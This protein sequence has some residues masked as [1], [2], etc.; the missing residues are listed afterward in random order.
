VLPT[1]ATTGK[2]VSELLA[3]VMQHQEFRQQSGMG[4]VRT[5]A[6]RHEEFVAVLRDEIAR[7]LEVGLDSG[8]LGGV[9]QQVRRG[10]IDP[11]RAALQVMN[12]EQAVQVL[13][14]TRR[15]AEAKQE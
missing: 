6:A 7:R 15:G 4:A 13:I 2:G 8:C 11:Y 9:L 12:D 1:E 10:D 5:A 14:G 3:A